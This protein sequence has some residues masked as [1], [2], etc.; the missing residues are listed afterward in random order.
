M[1]Y[2]I[3]IGGATATGKSDLAVRLARQFDTAVLSA[4]SRQFYREMSIGTAKPSLE[5]RQ[6]IT[7]YFIDFL[8]V[9]D[10]Y[11]VGGFERQAIELLDQLFLKNKVVVMAGG[12]G[13]F[14]RAVCEGLDDF[15]DVPGA[16]RKKVESGEQTNGIRWLQQELERLDPEYFTR[17]DHNNPARLRRA[18][19]VCLAS[20]LP[21]SHFLSREKPVRNFTSIFIQLDLPRAELYSRI[22]RRVDNMVEQG[23]EEEARLLLPY[24]DRPALHTVGY[25]EFFDYFDQ[26]ITREE[27][28]LKIK[29]HSRNYAKRQGTWFRKYGQWAVFHPEDWPG[30]LRFV[31]L[32]MESPAT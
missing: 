23:L 15:P 20:G 30:I 25:E 14:I 32:K 31:Q 1:N 4:D 19:E 11:S 5:E 24:R 18:L 6:G 28:I 8:S 2:L 12:S 13:L 3:V 21:Y 26:K 17:V 16:V 29:Q 9:A 7:H 10:E 27:A 22:E